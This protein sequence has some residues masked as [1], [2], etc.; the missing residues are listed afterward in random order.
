MCT[1]YKPEDKTMA[2]ANSKK[3]KATPKRAKLRPMT[4]ATKKK[5][6]TKKA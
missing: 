2:Q 4:A 1:H 5:R 3:S 6:K